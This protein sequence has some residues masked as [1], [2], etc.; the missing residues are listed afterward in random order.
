MAATINVEEWTGVTP[1]KNTITSARYCTE[2]NHNPG[3]D[4]PCVVPSSGFNYSYW[5]H[6]ALAISGTFTKVNNIRWYTDGT[7]GWTLGTDGKLLVGIRDA[8]DNGCPEASYEQS[9][10]TQG[11]TGYYMDDGTNGHDYYKD[12]TAEPADATDYTSASPLTIDS[13]DY[14]TA[15]SADAV[16]T[17][18]K[19]DDDATQGDQDNETFTFIYDEI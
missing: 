16:V 19:I 15:D 7:I 4:N 1:D 5:K 13:T 18:V 14:T 12:Q 10:G 17:Q 2:D 9:A 8:G 3:T 6:H 11:T